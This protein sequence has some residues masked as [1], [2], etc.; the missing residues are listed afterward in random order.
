M[1]RER[2]YA[3][4]LTNR[5]WQVI[6]QLLPKRPRRGRKPIVAVHGF[7]NWYRWISGVGGKLS[8]YDDATA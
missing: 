6:Q 2:N 5:Q 4:D 8:H 1:T 7:A 3:S